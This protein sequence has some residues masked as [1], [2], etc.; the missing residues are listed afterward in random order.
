MEEANVKILGIVAEYNPFHNGHMYHIEQARKLSHA[1][2][3]IC[4]MSGNFIQRGEPAIVNKWARAEMAISCGV[5][6]VIELPSVYACNSAEFFAY[7][8]VK[9]L[10]SLGI[11]DDLCFGSEAGSIDELSVIAKVLV[12]EP[13]EYKGVLKT[14]L[15][16]GLSFPSARQ[17]ALED[18]LSNY[19]KGM[20]LSPILSQALASPNSILG[21]EYLK[22]LIRLNS[23]IRPLM[24]KRISNSYNS[25][26][27]TGMFS[28]ATSIRKSIETNARIMTGIDI[29]QGGKLDNGKEDIQIDGK[30][31]KLSIAMPDQSLK[32]LLKEFKCGRGPVFPSNYEQAMLADLRRI[33]S[34]ALAN[35]AGIS[36]GFENRLKK[37]ASLSGSYAS[38]IETLITRR[39]PKTRIQRNIINILAGISQQDLHMFK[40]YGGPQY[41][42]VLGFNASG[43]RLLSLMKSSSSLPI[44]TRASKFK[45]SCNPLLTRMLEIEEL[46]TDLYVLGYSNPQMRYGGQEF[47]SNLVLK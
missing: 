30:N 24:I 36:E 40:L 6:L 19:S 8:A 37:A 1:D 28:S 42:R 32:I 35:I 12:S 46:L 5:D 13:E 21:I 45:K 38:L 10:D 43:R 15:K 44:I 29:I 16:A 3:V 9:I 26:T 34:T 25:E 14:Y 17:A 23:P 18:Y 33:S 20:L 31:V 39:Y 27:L 11:V 2:C 7:G 22:A 47:T 41:A 4:I